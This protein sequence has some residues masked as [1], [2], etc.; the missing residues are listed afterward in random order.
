MK[1]R[2]PEWPDRTLVFRGESWDVNAKITLSEPGTLGLPPWGNLLE[3]ETAPAQAPFIKQWSFNCCQE[4]AKSLWSNSFILFVPGE[5]SDTFFSFLF[6]PPSL[7]Y[8]GQKEQPELR[9]CSYACISEK[10]L[11]LAQHLQHY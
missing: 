3:G 8:I 10:C 5:P 1:N 6:F 7:P 2:W 4:R 11:K 9:F